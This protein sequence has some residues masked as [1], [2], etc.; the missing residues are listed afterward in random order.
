MYYR[1]KKCNR[2]LANV[3]SSEKFTL[4]GKKITLE[5]GK[6]YIECKCGEKT[7]IILEKTSMN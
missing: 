6:L 3:E 2:F 5:T 4:I 1:C 7:E